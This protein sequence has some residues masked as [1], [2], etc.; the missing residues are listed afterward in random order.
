MFTSS[1]RKPVD[2][3]P[4]SSDGIIRPSTVRKYGSNVLARRL[5]NEPTMGEVNEH[6]HIFRAEK[7]HFL[8]LR[9][10]GFK[11]GIQKWNWAKFSYGNTY[12]LLIQTIS[13]PKDCCGLNCMSI[14]ASTI[15]QNLHLI[16]LS[17]CPSLPFGAPLIHNTPCLR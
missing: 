13:R 14:L 9:S 10:Y 17:I 3:Y 2:G 11:W 4:D 6:L 16:T 1:M 15:H 8:V 7:G 12:D 5:R